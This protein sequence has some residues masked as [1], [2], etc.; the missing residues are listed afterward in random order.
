[1]PDELPANPRAG[2]DCRCNPWIFRAHP[3]RADADRSQR[4]AGREPELSHRRTLPKPSIVTRAAIQREE[5]RRQWEQG[6][7]ERTSPHAIAERSRMR[8]YSY[9]VILSGVSQC[10]TQSKDL[11][12]LLKMF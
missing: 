2:V 9:A 6:R 10:E 3:I 11:T 8:S 1:M 12:I 7:K 4:A 5:S